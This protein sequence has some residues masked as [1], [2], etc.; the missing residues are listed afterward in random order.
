MAFIPIIKIDDIFFLL[1]YEF[2]LLFD[3]L[4]IELRRG[5]HLGTFPHTSISRAS[6]DKK[7]LKLLSLTPFPEASCHAIFAFF[8]FCLSSSM[9]LRTGSLSKMSMSGLYP[10]TRRG[11][12]PMILY[13]SKLIT[14]VLTD[15]WDISVW[16]PSCSEVRS[17]DFRSTARQHIQYEWPLPWRN[18]SFNCR[19][20]WSDSYVWYCCKCVPV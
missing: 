4:R 3:L 12:K 5:L 7:N 14:H 19:R 6:A 10:W 17:L 13:G 8:R 2:V 11:S 18:S 1:L 9:S 20:C 15:I 16:N